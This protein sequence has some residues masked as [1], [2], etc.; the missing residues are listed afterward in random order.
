MAQKKRQHFVSQFLLKYF[1]VED[2][3]ELINFY[4]RDSDKLIENATVY[5][6]AQEPYFYGVDPT[7]EDYLSHFEGRAS[8]VIN[9]ILEGKILPKYQDKEYSY[10]LHFIMFYAFRTRKSV[11]NTEERINSG[12]KTLSKYF[13]DLGKI[14]FEKYRIVHPEPAA[15]NLASYMDDWVITYDLNSVLII[16]TTDND[17][18]ISDNP[19]IIYNPLMLRRGFFALA[20]G[21]ANKGLIVLFPLSPKAYIMLYDSWAYETTECRQIID[22]S[23]IKDIDSI[24]LLQSI[25]CDNVLFYSKSSDS[26]K[27]KMVSKLGLENKKDSFVNDVMDH[28][29]DNKKKMMLSYYLEHNIMPDLSFIRENKSIVNCNDWGTLSGVRNK[30]IEDWLNLDKRTLRDGI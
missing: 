18:F 19:F 4:N 23:D 17:F 15:F 26:E 16:N 29:L 20:N 8:I 12:V 5:S 14:D 1:S 11:K 7:F 13:T 27:V 24:N 3:L 6:Q 9:E 21:L 30:E 25:A 2:N 28:P 22:L 10:L